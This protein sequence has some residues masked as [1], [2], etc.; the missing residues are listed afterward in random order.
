[1]PRPTQIITDLQRRDVADRI[2]AGAAEEDLAAHLNMPVERVKRMFR[3]DLEYYSADAKHQVLSK[4]YDAAKSGT[5]TTAAVFWAKARYGWR[6]TG[7][8]DNNNQIVWPRLI[9]DI[10]GAQPS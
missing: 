4:L 1:M 7:A 3:R 9:V 2:Q 10:D 5:N 6:D 8:R